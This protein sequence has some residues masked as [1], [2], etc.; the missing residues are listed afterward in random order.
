MF[1]ADGQTQPIECLFPNEAPSFTEFRTSENM[2][3]IGERRNVFA[4]LGNVEGS[5][6]PLLI[7]DFATPSVSYRTM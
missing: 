1:L 5:D 6:M 2:R 4:K 7:K 3:V